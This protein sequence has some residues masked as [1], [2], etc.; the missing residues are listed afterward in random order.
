[1]ACLY[2]QATIVFN[3]VFENMKNS[4]I[5][6]DFDGTCVTHEYPFV[7]KDIGA[8]PILKRLA[9]QGHKLILLTMRGDQEVDTSMYNKIY[10]GAQVNSVNPLKDAIKWFEKNE[11][12]LYSVNSN[13]DQ[14][15]WTNSQKVF[16]NLYIDDAALGCPLVNQKFPRRPYV[17]W[18]LVDIL[19]IQKGYIT[20]D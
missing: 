20:T 10:K 15:S 9:D 11:I 13:P 3:N 4:F 5:C 8:A 19:L 12:P 14:T 2:R 6:V 1:M 16:G 17:D 7:G 18:A